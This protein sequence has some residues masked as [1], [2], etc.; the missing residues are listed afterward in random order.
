VE[1]GLNS[2]LIHIGV[3]THHM[4]VRLGVIH[5]ASCSGQ[6]HTPWPRLQSLLPL[7]LCLLL[8]CPPGKRHIPTR[9]GRCLGTLVL[10][11]TDLPLPIQLFLLS[12]QLS[13]SCIAAQL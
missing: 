9:L 13:K 7:R 6:A 1:F 4:E 12:P 3:V 8:C 5:V 11:L 2:R 10:I